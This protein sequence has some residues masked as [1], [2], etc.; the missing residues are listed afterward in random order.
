MILDFKIHSNYLIQG[1][2]VKVSWETSGALFIKIHTD[3][4]KK[5]WYKKNDE[6][7]INLS[8]A[9]KKVT[10]Y[11]FGFKKIQK[12]EIIIELNK[13]KDFTIERKKIKKI[14]FKSKN[15]SV[16]TINNFSTLKVINGLKPNDF[17]I[18]PKQI[19]SK[20]NYSNLKI[21]DHE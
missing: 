8:K 4:W 12:K 21:N 7:E 2:N 16:E 1:T 11:A 13:Q 3:S 17:I 14:N 10:L 20:I 18:K 5:G 9:V 6:I 19:Q 15:N